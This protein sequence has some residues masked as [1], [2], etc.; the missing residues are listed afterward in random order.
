MVEERRGL[1]RARVDG[2]DQLKR[3]GDQLA[4]DEAHLLLCDQRANRTW[5]M[6]IFHETL[7]LSRPTHIW[8]C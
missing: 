6:R 5:D 4:A 8:G 3:Y 1:E 2:L 7:E